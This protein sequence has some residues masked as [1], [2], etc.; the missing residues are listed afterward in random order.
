MTGLK[1]TILGIT[2]LKNLFQS[3][4]SKY[5]LDFSN[6]ALSSFK[7]R[8]EDFMYQYHILN[9]DELVY[10]IENDPD[11]LQLMI[12]FQG[13]ESTEMFRDPE[14]WDELKNLVLK[15]YKNSREIGIWFPDCVSGEELYTF[16]IICQHLEY[17]EKIHI[18]VTTFSSS[19]IEKIQKGNQDFKKMEINH[20]NYERFEQGRNLSEYFISKANLMQFDVTRF[21]N[22]SIKQHDLFTDKIP[23]IFDIILFRN[24]MLYFNPQLKIEALKKLDTALKPGGYIAVGIKETLDYPSWEEEYSVFSESERIYKKILK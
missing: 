18:C 5:S 9:F 1:K 11:F 10:K 7:R 22:F 6:Y 3:I 13:V 19:N 16:L 20:A 17:S 23:G 21:N 12:S 24:K 14:F 4:R 2:D 15:R 8:L